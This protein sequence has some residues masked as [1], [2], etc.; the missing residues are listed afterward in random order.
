MIGTIKK[1]GSQTRINLLK[2]PLKNL[3]QVGTGRD[4]TPI[5]RFVVVWLT[6]K[7]GQEKCYPRKGLITFWNP[8]EQG[9]LDLTLFSVSYIFIPT[10]SV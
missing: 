6:T 5:M 8:T 9:T 4:V 3:F 7:I 10:Y 1:Q 2:K